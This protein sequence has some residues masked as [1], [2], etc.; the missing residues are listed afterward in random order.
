MKSPRLSRRL[1]ATRFNAGLV[2]RSKGFTLVEL[3][4]VITIIIVLA[5]L[6]F[7]IVTM[8]RSK[9]NA[10]KCIHNLRGWGIAIRGYASDNN[11]F[12]QFSGWASIG[13]TA[14]LFENDLGGNFDSKTRSMDGVKVWQQQ[15][16]RRCPAQKW[17]KTGNGPVGYGF[18]RP[19][20]WVSSGTQPQG[21][22]FASASDPGSLLL[23]IDCISNAGINLGSIDDLK[24]YV[25][26]VC[27][28][29]E[30][31]HNHNVHAVFGDGHVGA[32]KWNDLDGDNDDEKAKL[33][34]WFT[35]K[36]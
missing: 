31:R 22:N 25:A 26:P 21:Y 18:V 20:P 11:G 15:I 7:P 34:R 36:P 2:S 30:I 23:M 6:I 33:T 19:Q 9:A 13:G 10:T 35:L 8:V 28:G 4:V 24:K 16:F 27:Q 5:A 17:D 1:A 14:R 32:Y 3:L 12:V 29:S